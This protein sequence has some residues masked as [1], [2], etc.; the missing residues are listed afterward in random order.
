[1]WI[2][3]KIVAPGDMGTVWSNLR[4]KVINTQFRRDLDR[5]AWNLQVE[6][7]ETLLLSMAIAGV[8]VDSP[9]ALQA[10]EKSLVDLARQT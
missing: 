5:I 7:I 4:N 10:I 6:A 8:D 1:M 2:R 3:I 9:E